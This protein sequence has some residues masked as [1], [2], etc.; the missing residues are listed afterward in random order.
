MRPINILNFCSFFA[1]GCAAC[2]HTETDTMPRDLAYTKPPETSDGW[3]TA[4]VSEVGLDSSRIDRLLYDIH[5]KD[6]KNIYAVVVVKD[7]MLVVDEYF[8]GA[9]RD[10]IGIIA[11]ELEEVGPDK[12]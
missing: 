10:D 8:N 4:S 3:Q 1:I 2:S 11:S 9:K 5:K 12:D 6:L 7:G